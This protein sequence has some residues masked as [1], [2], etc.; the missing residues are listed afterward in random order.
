[1]KNMKKIANRLKS[2]IDCAYIGSTPP[3][4]R[5]IRGFLGSPMAG[6]LLV[7]G[8]F[9]LAVG[10]SGLLY[11]QYQSNLNQLKLNQTQSWT[12]NQDKTNQDK[13][14]ELIQTNS[15]FAKKPKR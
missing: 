2:A 6:P 4:K 11:E 12:T 7:G 14:S 1:M 8:I 5:L 13:I 15:V 9:A 10:T 3:E